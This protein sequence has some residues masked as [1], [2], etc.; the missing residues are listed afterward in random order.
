MKILLVLLLVAAC[1]SD[2]TKGKTEAEK[3]YKEAQS[4]IKDERYILATEKLNLIKTQHPYSFYATPA[5]LLLAEVQYKQ[6]NFIEAA[7]SFLLFRDFHPKHERIA[8]VV[9]MIGESYYKQLPSTIDRDLEA[10]AEA[11]KFYQELLEKYPDDGQVPTA[12]KRIDEVNGMLRAKDQYVADFYFKTGV[13]QAARWWY[14]DILDRYRK[15][16]PL[17]A[18]A[19]VRMVASSCQMKK[20]DDCLLL[21]EKFRPLVDKKDRV[22]L[23]SWERRCQKQETR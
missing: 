21:A 20:W 13:W 14:Q 10:G 16:D 2:G 15:G 6:E 4:L 11:L 17:P 8:W 7:A 18:H 9:F 12:R 19:M 5:E 23:R 1:S 3:L 22:E